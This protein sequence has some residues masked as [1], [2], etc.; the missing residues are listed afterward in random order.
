MS[1]APRTPADKGKT[2]TA[3]LASCCEI[4]AAM[5]LAE[6]VIRPADVASYVAAGPDGIADLHLI[7]RNMHCPSCVRQIEGGLG[8][9]AGVL[10]ARLN[11]TT[12]RLHLRWN[13]AETSAAALVEKLADL[14]YEVSPYDPVKLAASANTDDRELLKAMAVAGFAAANV[15]LISVAVWAG[16]AQDMGEATRALMHWLSALIALPAVAYSGRPFFR[17]ALSAV[18]H[19]R[20]NM[21]VPISL[22]V[23]LAAGMSLFETTRGGE[24]VYFDASVSLLFFLLIG[25][26]LDRSLRRKVESAAQ[27]LLALKAVSA[28][29]IGEDGGYISQPIDLVRPGMKVAVAAGE[30]FPVDGVLQSGQTE[31]D[32]SMVT[33]ESVP[34]AAGPG[35]KVFAGTVNLGAPVTVTVTA[36]D[37]GTLLSE[38]VGLMEAAEQGRARYVRL[39]DRMARWYAPVVHAVAL[40]TFAGWMTFGDIGWQAALLVSITV[41]IV[42]CPCALGLAVPAVQAGAVGRLLKAGILA[43][44]GDGLERLAAVDTIVFDKTGTLTLGRPELLDRHDIALSD[45][46]RAASLAAA[47]RHPLSLAIRR[48][49]G[50]V[51]AMDDVEEVPGQGL[52]AMD[53]QTEIRLGRRN[54]ARVGAEAGAYHDGPELWL[55]DGNR[56]TQFRF[57]DEARADA[58][59]T[60]SALRD[61]GFS[62]E[63]LSG[64]RREAVERLARDVGIAQWREA[65]TPQDKIARLE[66]LAKKGRKVCMV[67]DGLNDAPALAAA[68][69]SIS[70]GTAADASQTAADF[71]FQGQRLAPVLEAVKT[72]RSARVLVLQNFALALAY[73]VIAV[74]VAAAGF[75]TPLIA[76]IAMSASSLVV[77]LNALRI[78]LGRLQPEQ[79]N[80]SA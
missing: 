49:A 23:I 62:V 40:A 8:T 60:V 65:C 33:G 46:K 36:T 38:I 78:K 18:S 50:P 28:T 1:T 12:R 68:F 20:T 3:P 75:A 21:D 9:E 11:A 43:K 53:G 61:H 25:R 13:E 10:L 37:E 55:T 42:T 57:R 66:A 39:A 41:L 34:R 64:D 58:R 6:D 79:T 63:L 56:C 19:G 14:G 51:A 17:S 47:S 74:P 48:V 4:A 80:D 77:T 16:L 29:V 54:F 72:A 71:I 15:M 26:F 70:P 52:R 2:E 44:S 76:A 5:D 69:A 7:V 35:E 27:N 45:L 67:G 30:R 24:H 31:I 59:E 32:T 22:A 73:N